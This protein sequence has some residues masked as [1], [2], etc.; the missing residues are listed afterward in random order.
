[1]RAGLAFFILCMTCGYVA[2]AY[3]DN[4]GENVLFR[5]QDHGQFQ[6]RNISLRGDAFHRNYICT[7][8]N[9]FYDY[10]AGLEMDDL[11][12]N[13]SFSENDREF[14]CLFDT[15]QGA[16]AVVL[17]DHAV[18]TMHLIFSISIRRCST[19]LTRNQHGGQIH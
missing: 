14:I 2:L 17:S 1:M 5:H 8:E 18:K 7:D 6:L 3:G 10:L 13:Y 12:G 9:A 11:A 19:S 4:T 15:P 16:L